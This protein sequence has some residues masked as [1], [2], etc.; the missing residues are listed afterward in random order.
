VLG[1]IFHKYISDAFE[2][3]HAKLQDEVKS[4]ADPEDPDEYRRLNI[5]WVQP[6]ARWSYLR[7]RAKNLKIGKIVDN[8][9]L[10]I[11]R[12]NPGLQ[13]VLPTDY[14][15]PRLD[16]QRLGQL[17]DIVGNIGLGDE[18]S[19]SKDVLGRV[20]EYFFSQFASAEGKKGGQFYTPRCVAYGS[21]S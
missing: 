11:E 1:L 2:E 12:D 5:F 13:G 21:M 4:G 3:Q 9:M 8:S 7:G 6:E 14:A 18:E 10:A 17:I 19:R 15:H 20:Y 16:K